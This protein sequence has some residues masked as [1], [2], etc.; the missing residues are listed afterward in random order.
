LLSIAIPDS[1]KTIGTSALSNCNELTSV[2]F[3]ADSKLEKI[4]EYAFSNTKIETFYVPEN[5]TTFGT[6]GTAINLVLR[7]SNLKTVFI[8]KSRQNFPAS[9]SQ[10]W[11][12]PD[13]TKVYYLGEF[14]SFNHTVD[15]VP[16]EYKRNINIKAFIEDNSN[17]LIQKIELPDGTIINVGAN[18]WPKDLSNYLYQVDKNA[19]FT[20]KG[21][22]SSGSVRDYSIVIDDIGIPVIDGNDATIKLS[23]LPSLTSKEAVL[24]LVNAKATDEINAD[25]NKH[26]VLADEYFN[27]VKA[28]NKV[29]DFTDITL[30]ITHPHSAK[31][32]QKTVRITVIDDLDTI[33]PDPTPDDDVE[34]PNDQ[35]VTVLFKKGDHGSLT[36]ITKYFV[37]KTAGHKLSELTKPGIKADTG[38]TVATP[39]FKDDQNLALNDNTI[40]NKDLSYTAQYNKDIK[41]V[42]VPNKPN[43]PDKPTKVNKVLPNTGSN[44]MQLYYSLVITVLIAL[45][46]LFVYNKKQED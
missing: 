6:H 4:G 22:H 26:I 15:K 16:H 45:L 20:F 11:G 30:T 1:V 7:S 33:I 44:N 43:L 25:L 18:N 9:M 42:V 14:V 3:S 29:G 21:T 19:T 13:T 40:I 35:Y 2:T 23:K 37:L 28:L 24:K 46:S 31:T 41:P 27:N 17:A 12:G 5:V 10:P 38:Y 34:K 8:N 36:G 39:N 32:A